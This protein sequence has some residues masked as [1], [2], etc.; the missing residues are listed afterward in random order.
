MARMESYYNIAMTIITIT[1]SKRCYISW[2]SVKLSKLIA[3]CGTWRPATGG[4]QRSYGAVLSVA[5]VVAITVTILSGSDRAYSGIHKLN[6]AALDVRH[7]HNCHVAC[8]MWNVAMGTKM[9]CKAF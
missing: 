3:C 4:W 5:V 2:A 1:K 8:G 7:I 6:V 9:K